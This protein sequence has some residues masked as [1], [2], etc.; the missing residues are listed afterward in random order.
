MFPTSKTHPP[1]STLLLC[2]L[3]LLCGCGESTHGETHASGLPENPT[4][5]YY[6]V[7]T[8]PVPLVR[9]LPGRTTALNVAE[10]RPQVSGIILKRHFEEG[11]LVQE[12]QELYEIDAAVY[13]ANYD[14][15]LALLENMDSTRKRIARLR[16]TQ[17]AS[18]QEHDDAVNAWKSAKA[19]LELAR[20]DLN[21][22]KVKAPLTGKIGRSAITV[23]AL[24]TNG[25]PEPMAV[26]QQIDPIYV[27]LKPAVPQ[28][29]RMR[30][31]TDQSGNPLPFWQGA[32][33]TLVL[34]DGS[35]YAQSGIIKFLDN[36]VQ[37][38]TGTIT[39]RAE[40]PNPD[41]E[42]LPG[43]F[44]RASVEEGVRQHGVLIPQEALCRDFKGNPYVWIVRDDNT[45]ENR[46]VHSQ[47]TL[48]NTCLV[49]EGLNDG[50]R[51]V[52]E[53]I[54]F[55]APEMTVVPAEA[56]NIEMKTSFE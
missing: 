32:K 34:E 41:G 24:V 8:Q 14:K 20:L 21:Y 26:I 19:D 27:D 22:C 33:V 9:E 49:D 17:A 39:L 38:D 53:G 37:E 1:L 15:A 6:V 48:G 46:P 40:I 2:F 43:M 3:P 52:I 45:I 13:Q 12:G 35:R 11:T 50:D 47:T 44:V 28:V 55:V 51:V 18:E 36:H 23:G 42:L 56:E 4:V 5:S 29:L 30:S 16:D 31:G 10:V 54:Q 25:Q 7:K